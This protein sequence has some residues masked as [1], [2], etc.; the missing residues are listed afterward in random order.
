TTLFRPVGNRRAARPACRRP[1]L[2]R[3]D[4]RVPPLRLLLTDSREDDR[5]GLRLVGMQDLN[6]MVAV[7]HMRDLERLA[8]KHRFGTVP[9]RDERRRGYGR[10]LRLFRRPAPR[11][12][13]IR[14]TG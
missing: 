2:A 4:G 9:T 13:A 5:R 6:Y 12:Q 14:S 1:R 10:L 8:Q 11:P 7:Q 3:R